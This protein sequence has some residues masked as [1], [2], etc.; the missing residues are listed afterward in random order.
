M[1][2]HLLH[3]FSSRVWSRS[4]IR[5][6]EMG[7]EEVT[8]YILTEEQAEVVEEAREG[9]LP[10]KFIDELNNMDYKLY[11]Q[12]FSNWTNTKEEIMDK[13][14]ALYTGNYEV[15]KPQFEVSDY[16]TR[17]CR[18]LGQ[19]DIPEGYTFQIEKVYSD[20]VYDTK[21]YHHALK[22]IRPATA[23]E[24]FWCKLGRKFREVQDGDIAK[25]V[26]NTYW[27]DVHDIKEIMGHEGIKH[28]YPS[29][30]AK[31]FPS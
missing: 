14:H 29:E 21:G 9:N 27:T 28:F 23:E 10:F 16:A 12:L 17:D 22:N 25:D 3:R 7:A 26:Y 13:I 11:E 6:S 30:Y 18:H 8:K 2:D 15:E 20:C 19:V 4:V 5:L 1:Y 24:Q 31:D